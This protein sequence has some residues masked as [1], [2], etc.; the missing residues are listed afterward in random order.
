MYLSL[1]AI[2]AAGLLGLQ[3]ADSEFALLDMPVN[4]AGLDDAGRA[5]YGVV[6]RMPGTFQE[7]LE[8]LQRDG[9]L[10][11]AL[12]VG[13]VGDYVGMKEGEGRMLGGMSE[14]ERRA[15]LIERY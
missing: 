7:A 11:E 6:Q 12:P 3:T 9:G 14:R 4:P 13:I 15:F 1:T 10:R 8:A 2:L 5:Q